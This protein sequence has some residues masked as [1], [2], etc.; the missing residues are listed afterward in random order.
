M[1]HIPFSPVKAEIPR[2]FRSITVIRSRNAL[3]ERADQIR[4]SIL[5]SYSLHMFFIYTV[6]I[7]SADKIHACLFISE[8]QR[9]I[10]C[11]SKTNVHII[12]QFP[13][14]TLLFWDILCPEFGPVVEVKGNRNPHLFGCFQC[15]K[16]DLRRIFADNRSDPRCMQPGYIRKQ[17]FPV[18]I[19]RHRLC[20]GRTCTVI[21]YTGRPHRNSVFQKINAES[22]TAV[23]D[24]GAVHSGFPQHGCRTFPDGIVRKLCHVGDLMSKIRQPCRNI[25]FRTAVSHIK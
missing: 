21:N 2:S 24:P 11:I 10:P 5:S 17:G 8:H 20:H 1:Y 19:R 14:D 7:V 12:H 9:R 25:G 23:T 15:L 13:H 16:S 3:P 4:E 6:L 22:W 18:K